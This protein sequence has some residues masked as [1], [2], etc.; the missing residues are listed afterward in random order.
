MPW[1]FRGLA[2]TPPPAARSRPACQW[3][4]VACRPAAP[5]WR[6]FSF[7]PATLSGEEERVREIQNR[8]VRLQPDREGKGEISI[9][10]GRDVEESEG[11]G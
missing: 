9:L 2:A 4:P 6:L 7:R 3:Q 5:Q 1:R 8:P 11:W 10:E